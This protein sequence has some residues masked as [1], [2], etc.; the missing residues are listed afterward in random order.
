M[1]PELRKFNKNLNYWDPSLG[2]PKASFLSHVLLIPTPLFEQWLNRLC[3]CGVP[4][5]PLS[6]QPKSS[7]GWIP[8]LLLSLQWEDE[9]VMGSK[10]KVESH[11]P[12]PSTQCLE[13]FKPAHSIP[14][15]QNHPIPKQP[16]FSVPIPDMVHNKQPWVYRKHLQNTPRSVPTC[17]S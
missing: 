7:V 2:R 17:W 9:K 10:G 13:L 15:G 12:F 8:T 11:P 6:F 16:A 3:V 1:L 4:S 14:K 5:Q